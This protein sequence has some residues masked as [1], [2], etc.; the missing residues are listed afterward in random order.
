ML[1]PCFSH[2]AMKSSIF[3]NVRSRYLPGASSSTI[4]SKPRRTWSKPI[5][6]MFAMSRSVMYVSK[7]SRSP[8]VILRRRLS[9]STLKR[10]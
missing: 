7:C 4:W 10:L 2:Q 6:L 8:T 5:A 3:R 1:R 9:G